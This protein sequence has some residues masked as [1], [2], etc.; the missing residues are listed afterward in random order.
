MVSGRISDL[1]ADM[2]VGAVNFG[3]R[4]S[5]HQTVNKWCLRIHKNLLNRPCELVVGLS[6][7][8]IFHRDDKNLLDL[9]SVGAQGAA[10]CYQCEHNQR[11][12]TSEIQHRNL[13]SKIRGG[14]L[15]AGSL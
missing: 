5:V 2:D 11:S 10:S 7:V 8:V 15:L 3:K 12:E 1:L 9:L 14:A 4:R 6:P 13:Q